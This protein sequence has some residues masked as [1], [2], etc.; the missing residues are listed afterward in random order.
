MRHIA[1]ILAFSPLLATGHPLSAREDLKERASVKGHSLVTKRVA[2]SP[3]GKTLATAGMTNRE[4]HV[5]LWEVASSK[6]IATLAFPSPYVESVAFSPDGHGP[7]Y[8]LTF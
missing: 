5:I 6:E 7:I 3:D 2:L 8:V 1:I 4:A